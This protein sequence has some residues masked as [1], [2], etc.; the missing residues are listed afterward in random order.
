MTTLSTA[1]SQRRL[2]RRQ[3]LIAAR[4]PTFA[5]V[6]ALLA[7]AITG[8]ADGRRAT[9]DTAVATAGTTPSADTGIATNADADTSTSLAGDPRALDLQLAGDTLV[10]VSIGGV[11][12]PPLGPPFPPC[13]SARTPWWERRVFPNETEYYVLYMQ[14]PG[15]G[16]DGSASSDTLGIDGEYRVSG[17]TLRAFIGGGNEMHE[18][19]SALIFADSVVELT[20]SPDVKRWSRRRASPVVHTP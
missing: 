1:P 12:L 14:R 4:A 2:R 19:F 9:D 5:V 7:I 10:L 18:S 17:D 8:C 20:S 6:T 3:V 11:P 16:D 15:C 13:D